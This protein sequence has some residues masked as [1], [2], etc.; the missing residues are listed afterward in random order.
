MNTDTDEV[1]VIVEGEAAERAAT[2]APE[3]SLEEIEA[4]IA[5]ANARTQ[6][7]VALTAQYRKE[8]AHNRIVTELSRADVEGHQARAP[9]RDA[10]E[11]GDPDGQ[12]SA[13]ARMVEVEARRARLHDQQRY[14][15]NLP[16]VPADVVEAACQ[17]R[18]A[19]TANW[20]RAHPEHVRDPSKMAK[21][22]AAHYD[23]E[24][25]GLTPDS[26]EYFAHIERRIGLRGDAVQRKASEVRTGPVPAGVK[27]GDPVTH[28][29]D[30]E[31]F[32]TKGE[33]E[34]ATDGTLVWSHGPHKGKPLGIVEYARRKAAMHAEG[35][36]NRLD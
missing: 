7:N 2:E 29:R 9:Y 1:R 26:R 11:T 32:L 34:R 21:L 36:Y 17:G 8:I 16:A 19:A 18:T 23:A 30:G 5:A 15:Q 13:Q 10:V 14:V 31:V 27:P 3:P 24:A 20:L 6:Q 28:V 25:E 12:A 4:R 22:T 33:R 35:R